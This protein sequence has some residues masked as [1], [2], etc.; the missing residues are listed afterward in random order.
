MKKISKSPSNPVNLIFNFIQF[1]KKKKKN[2]TKGFRFVK[3]SFPI[4]LKQGNLYFWTG[5]NIQHRLT[6]YGLHKSNFVPNFISLTN[7]K[8]AL[9]KIQSNKK[10][11]QLGIMSTRLH[12]VGK[13]SGG[14]HNSQIN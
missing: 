9:F 6:S 8:N 12:L 14:D 3:Y 11:F 10:E 13:V 4:Y 5:K 1:L 7:F 2:V